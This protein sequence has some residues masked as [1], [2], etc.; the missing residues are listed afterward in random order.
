M[1][2]TRFPPEINF[3]GP[4]VNSTSQMRTRENSPR[5][6]TTTVNLVRIVRR[7]L[8]QRADVAD[9]TTDAVRIT[10]LDQTRLTRD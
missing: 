5:N 4:L 6:C 2:M 9:R 10:R 7:T 3:R 1:E 8:G